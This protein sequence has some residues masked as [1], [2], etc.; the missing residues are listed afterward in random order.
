MPAAN[1]GRGN[2]LPDATKQAIEYLKESKDGFFL[3]VEGSQIDWAGHANDFDYMVTEMIDFD[4]TLGVALDF[5]EKDGNTLI[6]VTGDHETGGMALSPKVI[7][8]GEKEY[9]DYNQPDLTF[10]TGGHTTTL[11]PVFAYGPGSDE[12]NGI[13]EN[14]EI[15]YKILEVTGWRK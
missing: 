9:S 13:Y 12:F 6:V 3:A 8:D 5:A 10:A 2:F 4:K 11:I 1:K 14:N 15:F 7:Q